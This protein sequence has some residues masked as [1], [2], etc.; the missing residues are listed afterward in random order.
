[1]YIPKTMKPDC[2]FGH[3]K[4]KEAEIASF[5]VAKPICKIVYKKRNTKTFGKGEKEIMRKLIAI[6]LCFIFI[7]CLGGCSKEEVYTY[8]VL[9]VSTQTDGLYTFTYMDDNGVT[10][11]VTDYSIT[12]SNAQYIME[13]DEVS[14]VQDICCGYEVLYLTADLMPE[15][16]D[17]PEIEVTVTE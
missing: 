10:Q 11:K 16:D 7:C 8:P 14:Y 3:I 2:G 15:M 12:G 6:V 4:I 13:A 5:F 9:S 1:M 17:V